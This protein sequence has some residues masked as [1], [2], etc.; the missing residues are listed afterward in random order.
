MSNRT[1]AFIVVLGLAG[2][3][4]K[5]VIRQES[6]APVP[7]G[8]LSATPA[9][10]AGSYRITLVATT[11]GTRTATGALALGASD[12]AVPGA[13]GARQVLEGA[14]QVPLDSL[15]AT[16]PAGVSPRDARIIGVATG[17]TLT[18][19]LEAAA[20]ATE[21]RTIEGSFVAFTVH[22]S[23]TGGFDG[24]WRSGSGTREVTRG[25]FCAVRIAS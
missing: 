24:S 4:S 5:G 7:A 23:S 17:S 6:C 13:A 9:S 11:A 1:L 14:M 8:S 15:G 3:A 19:R 25:H 21:Q 18:L 12:V 16:P 10:L 22:R 2:C 20:P